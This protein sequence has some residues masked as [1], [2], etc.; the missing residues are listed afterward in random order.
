MNVMDSFSLKGKS[1]SNYRGAGKYGR[2]L[3]EG[4]MEAGAKHMLLQDNWIN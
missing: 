4:L 1:S 3:V 2:Q